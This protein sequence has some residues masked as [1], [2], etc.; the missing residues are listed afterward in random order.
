MTGVADQLKDHRIF[1]VECCFPKKL[2]G[3]VRALVVQ[4][5]GGRIDSRDV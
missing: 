3:S 5:T 1:L 2:V 4:V